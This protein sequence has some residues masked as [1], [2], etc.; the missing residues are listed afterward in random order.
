MTKETL[1]DT[2]AELER[3][4]VRDSGATGDWSIAPS[5]RY[6]LGEIVGA[7]AQGD[8]LRAVDRVLGREVALKALRQDG[9]ELD[10]GSF[11]REARLMAQIAHPNI[12]PIYDAGLLPDGRLFYTMPLLEQRTLAELIVQISLGEDMPLVRRMRLFAN[13]CMAVHEAHLKGVV[14]RDLKP[15]NMVIGPSGELLVTD[16]GLARREDEDT[17]EKTAA[18]DDRPVGTPLYMSPEQARGEPGDATSDVY[19]LGAILF[20]LLTLE[21]PIE[22]ANVVQQLVA[23][24]QDV[25]PFAHQVSSAAP[26]DLSQLAARCLSKDPAERPASALAVVEGIEGWLEGRFEDER[27]LQECRTRVEHAQ[28]RLGVATRLSDSIRAL[29]AQL[30]AMR[31]DTPEHAPLEI[32][33]PLWEMEGNIERLVFERDEAEEAAVA[34]LELALRARPTDESAKSAWVDV[35]LRRRERL[36]EAGHEV[37]ARRAAARAIRVGGVVLEQQLYGQGRLW[38]QTDHPVWLERYA[39]RGGVLQPSEPVAI[40]QQMD[41]PPGSYRLRAN[42]AGVDVFLPLKIDAGET[43]SVGFHPGLQ[44]ALPRGFALV[45]GGRTRLGGDRDAVHSEPARVVEM[46]GFGMSRRPVTAGEYLEWLQTFD[47]PAEA[48]LRGPRATAE[49]G[50]YWKTRGG[51]VVIPEEDSDGD[52][53]HPSFPVFGITRIDAEAYIAWR[54]RRDGRHYRLP[55]DDEWERAARGADGR[56]H[57]WGDRFDPA[58]CKMRLSRPGQFRPEPVGAFSTDVSPFGILDMAGSIAE[59]TRSPYRDDPQHA[60]VRGGAWSSRA[61]RCAAPFRGSMNIEHV[62]ADLGFRLLVDL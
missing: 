49:G 54:S 60:S 57:P 58:L 18:D 32:K 30:V 29:E 51:V 42:V 62:S 35:Q 33:Q 41:V 39:V 1:A 15:H 13:A 20:E 52:A 38:V 50:P 36:L 2:I 17:R 46:H 28:E 61:H 23:V 40:E 16:F 37:L 48:L 9:I 21:R 44:S 55:T 53:W 24:L 7:G 6:E 45:H 31:R 43:L 5:E 3:T 34:S 4:S 26:L 25:P 27:R 59:W 11:V 47:D 10:I 14:H 8:V 22:R 19:S 12:M 56:R